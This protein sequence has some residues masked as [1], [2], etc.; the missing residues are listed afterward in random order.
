MKRLLI[1][2]PRKEK[3]KQQEKCQEGTQIAP[4]LYREEWSIVQWRE[5]KVALRPGFLKQ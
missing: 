5:K 4:F 3:R 1:A 2:D